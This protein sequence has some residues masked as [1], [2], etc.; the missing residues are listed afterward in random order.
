VFCGGGKAA[1]SKNLDLSLP[2][3]VERRSYILYL[4]G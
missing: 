3:E 1:R 4:G 2:P